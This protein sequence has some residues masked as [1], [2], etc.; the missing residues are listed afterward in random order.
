MIFFFY[1][2]INLEQVEAIQKAYPD[3]KVV[4]ID[5]MPIIIGGGCVHCITQQMPY[6]KSF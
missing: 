6:G 5:G 2:N 1:D 3:R 4:P